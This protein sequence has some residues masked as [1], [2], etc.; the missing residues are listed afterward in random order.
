MLTIYPDVDG[1]SHRD[2][3]CVVVHTSCTKLEVLAIRLPHDASTTTL[4][5]DP[6]DV[7]YVDFSSEISKL[8]FTMEGDKF[9]FSDDILVSDIDVLILCL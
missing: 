6:N 7:D 2:L 5:F 1:L 3:H 4:A 9:V 8:I